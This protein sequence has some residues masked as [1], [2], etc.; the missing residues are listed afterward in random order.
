MKKKPPKKKLPFYGKVAGGNAR[1]SVDRRA[2]GGPSYHSDKPED[3][4]AFNEK[5]W[6]VEPKP[7]PAL[8][9]KP[10][11]PERRQ[12]GS[13]T[14]KLARGGLAW[15]AGSPYTAGGRAQKAV[16]HFHAGYDFDPYTS[17]GKS[18]PSLDEAQTDEVGAS[19]RM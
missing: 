19:R 10:P 12:D 18:G 6:D 9:I 7:P 16:S 14:K 8:P 2:D 4:K 5:L 15:D 17:T 13:A 3:I 1:R 11:G